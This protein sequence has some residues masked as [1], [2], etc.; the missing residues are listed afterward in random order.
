MAEVDLHDCQQRG[1]WSNDGCTER[2]R[3]AAP[4]PTI[5]YTDVQRPTL[6][7]TVAR[8]VVGGSMLA[9]LVCV[10]A[11]LCAAI[12]STMPRF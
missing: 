10:A 8:Y 9:V 11:W 4:Q 3:G 1:C 7:T 12:L 2:V 6:G 5:V